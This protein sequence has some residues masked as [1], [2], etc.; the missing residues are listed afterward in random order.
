[1]ILFWAKNNHQSNDNKYGLF[2]RK[3]SNLTNW[4]WETK[5]NNADWVIQPIEHKHF[6]T[7]FLQL[8]EYYAKVE[9]KESCFRW[10]CSS[11]T[12]KMQFSTI[13]EI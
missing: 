8:N 11:S 5:E 10:K 2:T 12:I 7:T 4:K 1:M 13:Q 3:I 9:K 6:D